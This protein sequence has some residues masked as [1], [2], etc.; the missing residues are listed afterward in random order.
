ME[1]TQEHD[2]Q[3]IFPEHLINTTNVTTQCLYLSLQNKLA[4]NIT[5]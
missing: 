2:E 4:L 3:D 1:K 5:F